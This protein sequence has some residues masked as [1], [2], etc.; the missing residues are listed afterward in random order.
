MSKSA[1]LEIQELSDG[2]TSSTTAGGLGKSPNRRRVGKYRIVSELGRGGMANVYL[3]LS[4]SAGGVSKLV[5]LKALRQEIA[6]EPGA[7]RMF[8]D[9]ARLAAQLNHPNVVQTYEVGTE[10][11]RHVIV[12]EHL[13]G[14]PLSRIL[15][16]AQGVDRQ[17]SEAMFL[18]IMIGLLEGL[19]YAHELKSYEG[20]PLRLV[21]RDV[22][23]QNVF[24]TYDG[25]V[26]VLDFGIAK[27]A[28][29]SSQT[30][31]GVIKG[32]IA[33]MAPEQM[34][35]AVLDARADVFSVGCIMWAGVTGQKLWKDL[36]DIQVVKKVLG[37]EIPNPR[38]VNPEC[39]EEL[40]R[41]TMKALA[42]DADQRYPTAR[43]LQLE[44]EKYVEQQGLHIKRREVGEFISKLFGDIRA[45]LTVHIESQLSE[46]AN[47]DTITP[48]GYELIQQE[49]RRVSMAPR[50]EFTGT[51]TQ[52]SQANQ[53]GLPMALIGVALALAVGVGV[54]GFMVFSK[55]NTSSANTAAV[56]T[57]A[58]VAPMSA[59]PSVAKANLRL[60]IEPADAQ[61][62]LDGRALPV[63][64]ASVSVEI[65]KEPY[66]LKVTA[67]GFMP[68]ERDLQVDGDMELAIALQSMT[69]ATTAA[70]V[71]TGSAQSPRNRWTPRRPDPAPGPA[72]A[73]GPAPD[74]APAPAPK[75]P[76]CTNLFYYDAAGIKKVRPEC[77]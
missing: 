66:K 67:A 63:G 64:I 30:T 8:L 44:L 19:H 69:P 72:P 48:S 31:T 75:G 29:S 58:P 76:D 59:A 3:A 77:L 13:E 33:Y 9:E 73:V 40:A 49:L 43:A 24:V 37:G 62:E 60:K 7:L 25:Q 20:E 12:M 35:G 1:E 18:Y 22:S 34:S 2:E 70:P 39:T 11:D 21:H 26:K 55:D 17:L 56:S 47:S 38:T 4:R 42:I 27:A 41:I 28:T 54:L 65:R 71:D 52:A 36:T 50:T 10:A 51:G 46:L 32:K 57:A 6:E 53:G 61:L 74:P 16:L 45:E 68:E 14:Q 5:V 23:P 15:R